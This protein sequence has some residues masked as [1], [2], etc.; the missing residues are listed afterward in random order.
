MRVSAQEFRDHV[1]KPSKYRNQPI[2]LDGIRFASKL[3]ARYFSQLKLREKAGEVFYVELQKRYPLIGPDGLLVATY[4]ADFVFWD[5][6]ESRQRIVDLKGIETDV[7][8][9]KKKLMKSLLGLEV[10][11]IKK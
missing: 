6:R 8:K 7:F 11:I 2:V 1:A 3:E 4:V 9:I 10:E 5:Q